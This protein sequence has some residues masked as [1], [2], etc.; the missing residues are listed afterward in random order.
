MYLSFFKT[1]SRVK[2]PAFN[3]LFL[4]SYMFLS[5]TIGL[6]YMP[7]IPIQSEN[8]ENDSAQYTEERTTLPYSL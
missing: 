3:S 5:P 7:P 6:S 8:D 1:D 4:T 2:M